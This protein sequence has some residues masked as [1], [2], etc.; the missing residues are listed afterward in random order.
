MLKAMWAELSTTCGMPPWSRATH[1]CLLCDC[2]RENMNQQGDD[3]LLDNCPCFLKDHVTYTA[4][5]E[6]CEILV[7]ILDAE[8]K[9]TIVILLV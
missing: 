9:D 8:A 1:P 5:C 2:D 4:G 3:V 6:R 7:G